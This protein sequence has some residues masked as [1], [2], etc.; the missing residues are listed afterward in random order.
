M[1]FT[2][3]R[4][5]LAII[6]LLLGTNLYAFVVDGVEYSTTSG[7]KT[8]SVGG[9]TQSVVYI[10]S[11]VEYNGV[12]YTVTEINSWG[13]MSD[14]LVDVEIAAQVSTIPSFNGFTALES[15][16]LPSS[17]TELSYNHFKGCT[18]LTS[19]EGFSELNLTT[20]ESGLFEDCSSLESI[21]LPENVTKISD[22]AFRNCVAL[23]QVNLPE[24]LLSIES[25]AFYGC[26][27][28]S[29]IVLPKNL[30]TVGY[31][32][33]YGCTSITELRIPSDLTDVSGLRGCTEVTVLTL[34]DVP[35][36]TNVFYKLEE[37]YIE[38][39]ED[40]LQLDRLQNME[41]LSYVKSERQLCNESFR[42]C[43][44]LERVELGG[45]FTY[46]PGGIF[47]DCEKLS[48]VDINSDIDSI[49]NSAFSG[50]TSLI[51]FTIPESVQKIGAS[52]FS[53]CS[54]LTSI[55][56]PNGISEI[57]NNVFSGC[58]GLTS[59]YGSDNIQKIGRYAF[60]GCESLTEVSLPNVTRI[61]RG[62]FFNCRG[63]TSLELGANVS[64]IGDGAFYKNKNLVDFY[65]G[66]TLEE[67][68]NIDI[69]CE[70]YPE[71]TN[72]ITYAENFYL[73]NDE[74]L[75]DSHK[76]TDLVIPQ[77]I[78]FI[79]AY[80]F[81]GYKG[82]TSLKTE[83]TLT[84]IG[85]D[86]FGSCSNLATV[87]IDVVTIDEYAF[88]GAKIEDLVLG[89]SL[90]QI[91]YYAFNPY[92]TINNFTYKGTLR[93]WC[94][95][96]IA[97]G[98]YIP[99]SNFYIDGN[100]I[101]D[102]EITADLY[103]KEIKPCTFAYS[104]GLTSVTLHY[105]VE[106]VD[107]YAFY[108]CPNLT[109]LTATKGIT[110]IG[111]YAFADCALKS[112]V[113]KEVEV[114]PAYVRTASTDETQTNYEID[115]YAFANNTYLSE[116]IL[117][118]NVTYIGAYAFDGTA[119]YENLPEG[120][121]YVGNVA[122]L[123]KGTMPENTNF[124][125]KD[126]TTMISP[127]A[128]ANVGNSLVGITLPESVETIGN[129]AFS[130]CSNLTDVDM[131]GVVTIGDGAFDGCSNLVDVDLSALTNLETI[132]NNAF[133]R[134]GVKT[135]VLPA[136]LKTIGGF[137]FGDCSDITDFTIQ[138]SPNTLEV[139]Y[140]SNG[141]GLINCSSIENVYIGRNV[142]MKEKTLYYYGRPV[143]LQ[144]RLFGYLYDLKN[145]S[146]GEYVSEIPKNWSLF[147]AIGSSTKSITSKSTTPPTV[148]LSAYW[149]QEDYFGE[150]GSLKDCILYVPKG[151]ESAY[152]S[153]TF[154]ENFMNIS[155]KDIVSGTEVNIFNENLPV[156]Y[157]NLNGVK[158]VNP[159]NG[160]FIKKQ[161]N[162]T[163]KVV[164]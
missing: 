150:Y 138:D 133:S 98:T 21:T 48:N 7:T 96:D 12:V 125:I 44:S 86:A 90:K 25:N 34:G 130:Y 107:N 35:Y 5:V 1:K 140:S 33:F 100:L 105:L 123:Y 151:Y 73:K 78:D 112:V 9:V 122:Y 113:L 139:E 4:Q 60:S 65:Y 49:C 132:G 54:G 70:S 152:S 37:L 118:D 42:Q 13:D 84:K 76:L 89:A 120:M 114:Q 43:R 164:L 163:T 153:A 109:S 121:V 2:F 87:N 62:A 95:V 155:G 67:W 22:N 129:Y 30:N 29:G 68:L 51:D 93:N 148:E 20:I 147:D 57:E 85:E 149:Y 162:K 32:A 157:Y 103:I 19:V 63:V 101:T 16:V 119:W 154:W 144:Y 55:T 145:L 141:E 74:T 56:I 79:P 115:D 127:S 40:V 104:C 92:R 10:P 97:V 161:G 50:C 146:L 75:G 126:G 27:A 36:Y 64:Y 110:R 106:S 88:M 108:G 117:P 124:A 134:T 131:T 38:E 111:K 116:I 137:A 69:D 6:C 82:L 53:G 72:P 24:P 45:E 94:S 128:F 47:S 158:V 3:L 14:K 143:V 135:V 99:K 66:N 61:E 18:K 39:S 11:S 31:D 59:I 71:D 83:S 15:V 23:K 156:E 28:L 81:Y 26:S 17:L 142:S 58:S 136:N 102:L 46:F 160:I 91:N 41:T 8:A 80:S 77:G 159:K 52:A